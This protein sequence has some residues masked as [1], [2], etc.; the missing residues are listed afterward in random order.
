MKEPPDS[1]SV[2]VIE[3]WAREQLFS[4]FLKLYVLVRELARVMFWRDMVPVVSGQ[5][6]NHCIGV[7]ELREGETVVSEFSGTV[8]L[9]CVSGRWANSYAWAVV[10]ERSSG[11]ASE[12]CEHVLWKWFFSSSFVALCKSTLHYV[13]SIITDYT[14]QASRNCTKCY[15]FLLEMMA[16]TLSSNKMYFVFTI[17]WKPKMW[18]SR[19]SS[20]KTQSV[21]H[22]HLRLRVSNRFPACADVI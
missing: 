17:H 13:T 20:G 10:T 1:S 11:S 8:I 14:K 21:T 12:S 19:C 15:Y 22:S 5:T 4:N 2:R 6:D 7:A 9:S 3:L 16:M 18:W